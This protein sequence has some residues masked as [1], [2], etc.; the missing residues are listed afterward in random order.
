MTARADE[1]VLFVHST[2]TGPFLWAGAP[3]V[4]IGGRTRL[5]PANIGYSPNALVER[6]RTL[7]AADDAAEILKAVPPGDAPVHLV[8]HSYGGL[9]AL[10]AIRSLGARVA[11]VFFFEPVA[12]G[13][14]AVAQDIEPAAAEQAR[15]FEQHPW[16]LHDM[17]K[18]GRVEWQ[19]MFVDYW[20]RPG[21]WSKMPDSMREL[22]LSLGWKMFQEVRSVFFE[23]TPFADWS[24]PAP[25]TIA[26]G[27][28]TTPASRAMSRALAHERPNVRLIEVAGIGHMAPLTHAAKVYDEL[29]RHFVRIEEGGAR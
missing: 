10:H 29:A 27:E 13:A 9:V 28:R 26:F 22:S 18:G 25:T 4:A 6:G 24:L 21:S 19:E 8:A 7:T 15:M 23:R 16:F 2:G 5:H 3:D 20:N 17:D 11:S 14:L 12:F 1:F